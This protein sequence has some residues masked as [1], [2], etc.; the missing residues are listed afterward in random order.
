[1]RPV[2]SPAQAT[3]PLHAVGWVTDPLGR[4]GF[5]VALPAGLQRPSWTPRFIFDPATGQFLAR[6]DVAG[7]G[8][9]AG[10][11]GRHAFPP[12]TMWWIA[13][14]TT[15]WNSDLPHHAPENG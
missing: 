12:G 14:K 13:L 15:T 5:A 7:R 6:E 1:M 10:A 9:G 8:G 2:A 4:R 3:A 11:A